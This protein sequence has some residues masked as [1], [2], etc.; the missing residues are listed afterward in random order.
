MK[1]KT[2]RAG[3]KTTST[4]Y[5]RCQTPAYALDPLLLWLK[6]SWTIWECAA[7][8][9][10]LV[11]Y[12]QSFGFNVIGSDILTGQNFLTWQPAAWDCIITNPPYSIKYDFIERCY[13]LSKPFALL[14]PLETLGAS[15]A[16]RCFRNGVET[17]LFDKRVNFKMPNK[18]YSGN[19]AQF[20]TAWFTHGLGI[21]SQ[22]TF[23]KLSR[24]A[25]EQPTFPD[26]AKF[27][28]KGVDSGTK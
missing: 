2:N 14:M 20:P 3:V 21:G 18:G 13:G 16:Q 9:G 11:I 24:R 5:D 15:R 23:A 26:F 28:G 7:G 22:L 1:P 10:G 8:E 25:D 17:I 19:G 12:L 4:N 27:E 6:P